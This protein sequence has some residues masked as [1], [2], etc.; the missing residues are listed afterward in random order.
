MQ[1]LVRRD[2][3]RPAILLGLR[4]SDN[5]TGVIKVTSS[6]TILQY[7]T[8]LKL[9]ISD[10]DTEVIKVTNKTHRKRINTE[11]KAKVLAAVLGTEF[12]AALAVLPRMNCTRMI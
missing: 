5:D 3:R 12:L 2:N 4:D 9:N 8:G 1:R 7:V 11:E 6:D 10:K